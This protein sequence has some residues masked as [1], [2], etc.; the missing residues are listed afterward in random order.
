M[1]SST[2]VMTMILLQV[3]RTVLLGLRSCFSWIQLSSPPY[4]RYHTSYVRPLYST[5]LQYKV[6]WDPVQEKWFWTTTFITSFHIHIV[7][8]K[9]CINLCKWYN[10]CWEY[11][12]G[13]LMSKSRNIVLNCFQFICRTEKRVTH[14]FLEKKR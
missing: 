11:K 10:I 2:C 7:Y 13:T 9:C 6:Y 12:E 4:L 8:S 5:I 1:L 14:N 3:R